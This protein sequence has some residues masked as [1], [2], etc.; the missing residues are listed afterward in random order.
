MFEKTDTSFVMQKSPLTAVL[1]SAVL[2]GA[3]QI[4]NQSYFKAPIIWGAAGLLVY[5]WFYNQ[6]R[7]KEYRDLYLQTENNFYRQYRIFYRDQRDLFTPWFA[8]SV[9]SCGCLCGCTSF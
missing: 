5:G 9:K 2:P 6:D 3:G 4:Y 1:M 8:L 7:Y